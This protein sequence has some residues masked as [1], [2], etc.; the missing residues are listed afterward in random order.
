[1]A[2][3]VAVGVVGGGGQ[4]A[5]SA[6]GMMGMGGGG[7]EDGVGFAA[8]HSPPNR[9]IPMRDRVGVLQ[10][11]AQSCCAPRPNPLLQRGERCVSKASLQRPFH[12]RQR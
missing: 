6:K 10:S 12:A 4:E 11:A 8:V 7:E 2:P 3:D 9:C 5:P 1:M